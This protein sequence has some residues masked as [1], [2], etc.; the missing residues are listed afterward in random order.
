[1]ILDMVSKSQTNPTPFFRRP[2]LTLIGAYVIPMG[3][4]W[5]PLRLRFEHLLQLQLG[6]QHLHMRG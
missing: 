3:A 1:M 4:M 2:D 5:V 6:L